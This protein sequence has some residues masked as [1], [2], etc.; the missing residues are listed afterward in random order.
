MS[1]CG[2]TACERQVVELVLRGAS[3]REIAAALVISEYTV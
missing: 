3:T 2:L 1:A